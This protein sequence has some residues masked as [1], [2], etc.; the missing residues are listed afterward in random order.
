MKNYLPLLISDFYKQAHAEQYPAN[1]E[2]IVAYFTP[3][4]TRLEEGNLPIVFGLQG[5]IKDYLIERFNGDFF[6]VPVDEVISEYERVIK[7]TLTQKY[8]V[9]Q[10]I[11]ELHN[12]GYLPVEI[13][14]LPE[15]TRVPIK[16]PC[17][18]ISNTKKGFEWVAQFIES[19]M[20]CQL[21]FPMT[22]A[23]QAYKY[24][25]IVDNYYS[26][27]VDDNVPRSAAIAEF[28]F[29]GQEGLEGAILASSAFLTS[30]DKTATIPAILYLENY[31]GGIIENR[32]VATGMLSTEHS[33]MCS[34]YAIDCNEV[35]FIKRLLSE[36]Y[37][38]ENLSMVADSYDYWGLKVIF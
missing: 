3:R 25:K 22:I 12:L 24:R 19:I 29:R 13:K 4:M 34:N 2:F 32:D 15:G 18:E 23:S 26:T 20:S 7:N 1:I 11:R 31:Y 30:F 6:Q 37:P 21:W 8:C 35:D 33:V 14:S 10:K 36:I 27:T 9:S 5:F 17:F 28:G 38:S 16:V